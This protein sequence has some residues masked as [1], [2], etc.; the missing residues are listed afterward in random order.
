MIKADLHVHSTHSDGELTPKQLIDYA[1]EKGLSAISITDHDRV[2]ANKEAQEYANEKGI[3]YIPGIEITATPPEGAK[4]LHIVGLFINPDDKEIKNIS[5]RH[6]KYSI[7]TSKKIIKNL[8]KLGYKITFEELVKE[9]NNKH[10]GRPFIAK[11]LL[12]KYPDKLKDRKQVFN[13]LLGKEGKAFVK[14]RGTEMKEAIKIIH[15]AG[16]IA[17][18][19]HPWHLGENKEKIIEEFISFGGDGIELAYQ[20]KKSV[21]KKIIKPLRRFS[22][23]HRLVISGGTDFHEK[24]P[25]KSDLGEYGLT[26][27]E[28]QKLKDYWK[29]KYNQ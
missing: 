5:E 28:F 21:P 12:R 13:E 4:E 24:K 29:N 14:A 6:R 16:G 18:V 22:K 8:N 10:L 1:L 9:T 27:K 25:D 7:E 3:E 17:I 20:S 26:K 11:I 2:S 23:K 19:A 15:N